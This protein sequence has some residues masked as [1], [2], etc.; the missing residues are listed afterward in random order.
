MTLRKRSYICERCGRTIAGQ[1]RRHQL[2]ADCQAA[3]A[4]R[5]AAEARRAER[6]SA[7]PPAISAVIETPQT[8]VSQPAP[9]GTPTERLI[10]EVKEVYAAAGVEFTPTDERHVRHCLRIDNLEGALDRL[11]MRMNLVRTPSSYPI[12]QQAHARTAALLERQDRQMDEQD[13]RSNTAVLSS[14]R[15]MGGWEAQVR[16]AQRAIAI[17]AHSD[18]V[19]SAPM[20]TEDIDFGDLEHENAQLGTPG[21][22]SMWKMA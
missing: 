6:Q 20:G 10:A 1:K 5:K 8:A 4:A 14:A 21:A 15:A 16:G 17:D 7:A 18:R 12:D 9:A 2:T 19:Q 22:T 13:R 11:K 3:Y